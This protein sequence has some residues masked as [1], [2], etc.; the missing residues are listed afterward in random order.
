MTEHRYLST[1]CLHDQHDYCAA[2][3]G[4]QGA[5]RPATCKFC[6]AHCVCPCHVSDS[7]GGEGGAEV[8][9]PPKTECMRYGAACP[10]C[11]GCYLHPRTRRCGDCGRRP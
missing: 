3:T 9:I 11:G 1:G 6:D 2:M 10:H 4:Q 5:K 8:W 7:A